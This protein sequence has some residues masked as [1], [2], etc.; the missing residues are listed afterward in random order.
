MIPNIIESLRIFLQS[1]GLNKH[2]ITHRLVTID[3]NRGSN[4]AFTV[5]DYMSFSQQ[6][7]QVPLTVQIV[8]IFSF[9][10]SW[11]D[12]NYTNVQPGGNFKARYR[13]L[14]ESTDKDIIFKETYRI[15]R[16][17]RNTVI[18]SNININIDI[19]NNKVD[20][21]GLILS[22]DTIY[23]LY[24]LSCELLSSNKEVYIS[25]AYHIGV[26]RYYYN[27]IVTDL[28]NCG[29][30]DDVPISFL[31]ISSEIQIIVTLRYLVKNAKY[32]VLE[33]YLC[34]DMYNCGYD[35]YKADYEIIYDNNIYR[36]PEEALSENNMI[37][38]SYIG[39]WANK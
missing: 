1:H 32:L 28:Q 16:K 27:R 30:T 24:S 15:F 7:L 4:V 31:T 5:T 23:W 34:F 33:D 37:N 22:I 10:D 8:T 3:E 12:I 35:Y 18:H 13:Q 17:L 2:V 39:L 14:P 26:L 19:T 11:I 6:N 25:E 36:V 20:F 29:Y 9:L 21:D 38:L